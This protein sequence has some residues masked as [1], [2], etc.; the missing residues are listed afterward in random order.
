[1]TT[2][3]PTPDVLRL[4][5]EDADPLLANRRRLFDQRRGHG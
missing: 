5:A 4:H 2:T 1:M 3:Q